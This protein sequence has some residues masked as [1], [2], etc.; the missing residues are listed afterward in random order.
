MRTKRYEYQHKDIPMLKKDFAF[1]IFFMCLFI[2]VFVWQFI[3]FV[4]SYRRNDLS[5]IKLAES[6]IVMF[7]TLVFASISI[8]YAF[9]DIGIMQRIKLHGV[10]VKNIIILSGVKKN[11]FLK[12][13]YIISQIIAFAMIVVLVSAI[14]YAI[15]QYVYFTTFSFYLPILFFVSFSGFNSVYHIRYEIKTIQ[16][17]KA[18]NSYF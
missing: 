6:I 14:T 4:V 9:K 8:S 2:F 11:S 18:F 1:R 10:A 3:L 15:L 5:T 16:N 12:I 17:V 7:V 13:Y